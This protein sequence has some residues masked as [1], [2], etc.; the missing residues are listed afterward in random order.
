MATVFRIANADQTSTIDLLAGT[1]KL[2]D[3]SW[4]TH[5]SVPGMSYG[6][7]LFGGQGSF[8]GYGNV[9]ESFSLVGDT[10]VSAIATAVVGLEEVAAEVRRGQSGKQ[11]SDTWWLEWNADGESPKRSLIHALS[12]AYPAGICYGPLVEQGTIKVDVAITRHP[13]WESTTGLTL[14]GSG[15]SCN[16]GTLTYGAQPGTEMARLSKV[17]G[18]F[19]VSSGSIVEMWLG[20][21]PLNA[22][23]TTFVPVAEVEAVI[24]G[25]DA[26]DQADGEAPADPSSSDNYVQVSFA[27]TT[28]LAKRSTFSGGAF[29]GTG[30]PNYR[31]LAGRYLVLV[32]ARVSAGTIGVQMRAGYAVLQNHDEVYV[33][34]TSYM[35]H[36]LGEIAIPP[37]TDKAVTEA[38][39]CELYIIELWAERVSGAGTL[40]LDCVILMPS[41]HLLYY[42]NGNG[43]NGED[44]RLYTLPDDQYLGYEEYARAL[45]VATSDWRLPPEGGM[46]VFAGQGS[47]AHVLANTMS[48]T[49]T[50]YPRW[51]SFRHD[52]AS[53]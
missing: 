39:Y 25:T 47:T 22:G 2:Q 38:N 9:I 18:T 15:L 42:G 6:P 10:T 35:L 45:S 19:S 11:Y 40:D 27:T 30:S 36:C 12:L 14:S 31:H 23:L 43:V 4:T 53:T 29:V 13:M 49:M 34:N 52:T 41:E 5:T 17:E 46:L 3:H 16:G 37:W 21:R 24:N 8:T 33:E 48:V 28:T 50:V 32:R 26:T 51:L 1:L 44:V 7:G 20:I